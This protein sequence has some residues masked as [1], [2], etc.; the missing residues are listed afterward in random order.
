MEQVKWLG[1]YGQPNETKLLWC[2]DNVS[3]FKNI[4]RDK[5]NTL[6]HVVIPLS[7][8]CHTCTVSTFWILRDLAGC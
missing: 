5:V 4:S 3:L 6:S 2:T 7:Y 8:F 1:F